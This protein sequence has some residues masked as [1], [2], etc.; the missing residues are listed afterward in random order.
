MGDYKPVGVK[1]FY[2][3]IHPQYYDADAHRVSCRAREIH[4]A[5]LR[6][7]RASVDGA[8]LDVGC[9]SQ[10]PVPDSVGCDIS[11]EGLR[12]RKEAFPENRSV[13][14][15]ITCLPFRVGSFPAILAGL[16]FDHVEEPALAFKSLRSVS[17]PG[18]RLIVTVF[19]DETRPDEKYRGDK[20]HY[21]STDGSSYSVPSY[22]WRR[23][24][25]ETEAKKSG[26]TLS[27]KS[28]IHDTSDQDFRLLQLDFQLPG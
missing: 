12:V 15:D 16:L 4:E 23:D 8:I 1:E 25:L 13:C 2:D 20:L 18:G 22:G 5:L 24:E 7:F 19:Q 11:I 14:A 28:I 21:R 26:W 9:A 3:Q 17:G 10:A 27:S 6:S